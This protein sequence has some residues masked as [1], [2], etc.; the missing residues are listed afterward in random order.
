MDELFLLPPSPVAMPR[1]YWLEPLTLSSQLMLI[2]PSTF[3]FN[4][5]LSAFTHRTDSQFDMEIMNNIYAHDC[6][7]I[8]HRR[9]DLLTG[10]FRKKRYRHAP[11]LG[12]EEEVWNGT[13]VLQEA[14]FLHFSDWPMRKPWLKGD[15][16]VRMEVQ[17]ECFGVKSNRSSSG[18]LD[19]GGEGEGEEEDCTDRELW[20]SFYVEFK[21]RRMV[22][23]CIFC[24]T[25]HQRLKNELREKVLWCM[26]I[27]LC[28]N[29]KSF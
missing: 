2:E 1:A 9:Y 20:N 25:K 24:I 14:K 23:F 19:G 29:E 6:M 21:E 28:S 22:S 17:P 26:L 5:I 8:P 27:L 12:S 4:R 16:S 15:E 10:E 11:Y 13:K 18:E 7:I 3:E